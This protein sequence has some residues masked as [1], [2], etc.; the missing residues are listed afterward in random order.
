MNGRG[1]ESRAF[2]REDRISY[3]NEL[4]RMRIIRKSRTS[5]PWHPHASRTGT[6]IIRCNL[7]GR[8]VAY[9]AKDKPVIAI[10][11]VKCW[12]SYGHNSRIGS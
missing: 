2:D 1:N 5:R 4:F 11:F 12:T 10:Y 7:V 8:S 3:G 9:L 6:A